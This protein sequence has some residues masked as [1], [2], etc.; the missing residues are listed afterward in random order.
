[1]ADNSRNTGKENLMQYIAS[2]FFFVFLTLTISAGYIPC[3]AY[4]INNTLTVNGILAATYHYQ[5]IN[6]AD[7]L[8]RGAVPLQLEFFY[9]PYKNDVFAAKF[10]FAAGNGLNDQTTFALTPWAADLE[11]DVRDIN[12]RSRDYLLTAWYKHTFASSNGNSLALSG[13]IIDATD[14]LDEN[15]YAND[16]FTQFMNRALVNGPNAFL[17]SYDIGGAFQF[18]RNDLALSGVIMNIG[19]NDAGNNYNFYGLQFGYTL[20][21]NFGTGNYRIILGATGRE[22]P[23]PEGLTTEA[24]KCLLLS[25]DQEFGR[26]YGAWLRMGTQDDAAAITYKKIFSG[27]IFISGFLWGRKNDNIGIGYAYLTGGNIDLDTSQVLETYIRMGLSD[28]LAFSMD[29]Q[30]MNDKYNSAE[31]IDGFIYSIR[32]AAEF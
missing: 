9:E 30:Y 2:R 27:G 8:G 10:G 26:Y 11:D 16:E 4:D 31:K 5:D 14:Y 17:P 12:G 7:R 23:D 20:H 19:E 28:Y 6:D 22:F 21:T 15:E 18:N 1:M 29:I 32:A 13:G 25:F 3:H 24:R